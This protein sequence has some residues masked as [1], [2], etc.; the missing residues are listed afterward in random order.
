MNSPAIDAAIL[1]PRLSF[2]EAGLF[3]VYLVGWVY[4]PGVALRQLL[5]L[6]LGGRA[7]RWALNATVGILWMSLVY[8]ALALF[9][10]EGWHWLAA[11][12]PVIPWLGSRSRRR[13]SAAK[14]SPSV[15]HPAQCVGMVLVAAFVAG[16]VGRVASLV[17][18][19]RSGLRLY[20]AFYSDKL[21]STSD[22]VALMH[23]VP[24]RDMRFAGRQGF[25]H[26]FPR[27][28][29]A[30]VCRTTGIDFVR[31]FW[32]Y[33]AALGIAV[34]GLAVLAFCRR[35]LRSYPL[36]CVALVLHGLCRYGVEQKPLDLSFA[37]LLLAL[38]AV[39]RCSASR[40]WR[41]AGLAV[42]LL[43]M[44][45]TYEIFHA[46]VTLAGL[47]IWWL[48]GAIRLVGWPGTLRPR[49]SPASRRDAQLRT[50]IVV[51]AC[52]AALLSVRLLGLG[53]GKVAPPEVVLRNSYR[54]SYKHE[55][56][57]L[58]RE[59][60]DAHPVL[61][62][63]YS[64]KRGKPFRPQADRRAAR[65]T[66]RPSGLERLLGKAIF[67]LG[68]VGYFFVR[69][70]NVGLFGC[71]ALWL[72]FRRKP[73]AP[74]TILAIVAPIVLVGFAIPFFLS[75]GR[76]AGTQWWETPNIYRFATCGHVLLVL[77]GVGTMVGALRR[78]RR[79]VG[80]VSAVIVLGR[81][82]F[83]AAG[84]LTPITSFHLVEPDRLQ[85]LAFLRLD[86]P[87]GEVVIHPWVDDLIRD[88]ARPGQVSWVYKHHFMLGANLAG[89]PIY[90]EGK[91][92][93]AFST[94]RI[95]SQDVLK[96]SRLRR[97]FFQSPDAATVREVVED[98]AVR[99]VISD[100]EHPPP[101]AIAREWS[102]AFANPTVKIYRR[103]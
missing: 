86:V 61:D 8:F 51:P 88:D 62:T 95:S 11:L 27:L 18:Y 82:V 85:A 32:F 37:L 7:E 75:W 2:F 99:W 65:T 30:A 28:F 54:D 22:C 73:R 46:A 79:P 10:Q 15:W 63:L 17:Q 29:V 33:A 48:V 26:Y 102:L 1:V 84:H 52:L 34:E 58:L 66:D 24:P 21:A 23:E 68:F 47:A 76:S 81:L 53:G 25:S 41:W 69:F 20:G 40:R 78:W 90:F 60:P 96:R 42:V 100:T 45:P 92:E 9:D 70:L 12:L 13:A 19:D 6:R 77:I 16:H 87:F 91:E 14:R 89:R 3:L 36:A 103:F 59:S 93:H 71:A 49:F 38:L 67:E 94:G 74:D 98:G 64:W 97:Q 101:A 5:G 72:W 43:G 80:W 31:A 4:L 44:M 39:R 83:L 57:D 56:Q 50:L 35:L 55:W